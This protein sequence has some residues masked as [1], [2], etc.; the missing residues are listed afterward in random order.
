MLYWND[1]RLWARIGNVYRK[2]RH[3]SLIHIYIYASMFG[4]IPNAEI[5]GLVNYWKAFPSLKGQLFKSDNAPYSSVMAEDVKPVSYTH[6]D[7][8]KRQVR[9]CRTIRSNACKQSP[10][11]RILY[12]AGN[13]GKIRSIRIH[14]I[15]VSYTH[16]SPPRMAE[17]GSSEYMRASTSNFV[18]FMMR[19]R[20][21]SIRSRVRNLASSVD[22]G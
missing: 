13:Y 8:Y 17:P 14:G 16:L 9:Q 22:G 1:S 18:P 11:H 6:L 20:S 4:G 15:S 10:D 19:S 2:I 5:D 3:L 7:V 12:D 21:S